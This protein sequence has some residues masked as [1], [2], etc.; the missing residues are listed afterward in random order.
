M[1]IVAA[2]TLQSLQPGLGRVSEYD[3]RRINSDLR[4]TL[5]ATCAP[6]ALHIFQYQYAGEIRKSG[7][8]RGLGTKSKQIP[9]SVAILDEVRTLLLPSSSPTDLERDRYAKQTDKT[10]GFVGRLYRFHCGLRSHS[11]RRWR[12]ASRGLYSWDTFDGSKEMGRG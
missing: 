1:P 9:L 4:E 6:L 7:G 8:L 3:F 12:G 5:L 10:V 11:T 2:S